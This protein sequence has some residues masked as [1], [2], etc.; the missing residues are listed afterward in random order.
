M[1]MATAARKWTVEDVLALP[2]DGRRFELVDGVLLVNGVEVPSGDLD[3]LDPAMTP[4]ASLVHQRAVVKLVRLLADYVDENRVGLVV[5]APADVG[6]EAETV[7][8]PDVF[9]APLVGGRAPRI[10]DEIRT[11]LLAVEILSPSTARTDRVRKR[12]LYQRAGVGEYWIVDLDARAVERWK[13]GSDVG[14]IF[15]TSL[16]WSPVPGGATLRIGLPQFFSGVLE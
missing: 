6:L 5:V 14:E 9:V 1:V 8:Q 13:P 7:V 4:S 3:Q 15:T 10:L 16:E 2:Y 12:A 11:L